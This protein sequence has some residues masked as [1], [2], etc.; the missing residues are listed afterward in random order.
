MT[1]NILPIV[2]KEFRQIARDIRALAILIFFPAF[3]LLLV[4]YALN[5][6]VKHLKLAVYD[7]DRTARSRDLIAGMTQSEYF[8]YFVTLNSKDEIDAVLEGGSAHLVIVIPAD[9]SHELDAGNEAL[10][11][12]I[13]DGSNS[14]SATAAAGYMTQ[15]IQAY[16]SRIQ[17]EWLEQRGK[18]LAF[19]IDLRPKLWYNPELK[20]AK[21]LVPGL[22]GLILM[23]A[24]VISTSLSIVREK[25]MGTMEQLKTSPLRAEEII[26]GKTIPYLIIALFSSTLVLI[27]GWQLFD[28]SVRGN[29][30]LLYSAILLFL[31]AGL[32]QGMLI[33]SIAE[34]QQ[35][36]YLMSVFSSLLPAFL[37]SGFIFPI[38]SM[39]LALQVISNAMATKFFLS[40]L[41]SVI[42]KG[43][44]F[45]AVWQQFLYM[46][47]FTVVVLGISSLRLRR[48]LSR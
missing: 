15:A 35:V 40:I 14:N 33:S 45:E 20:T 19:P 23:I 32:G 48:E 16:S 21:Y 18:S 31:I 13:L 9:F 26:I 47:M 42:L 11:Q 24:T 27:L 2:K 38:S 28:V 46:G 5:F 12:V 39:P 7:E 34:T 22:F 8:D 36:A 4:G 29:L 3:M 10:I 44:G 6:D 41:R 37:L 17:T 30:F 43:V 1:L 25:E